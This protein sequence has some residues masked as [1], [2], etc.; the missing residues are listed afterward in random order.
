MVGAISVFLPIPRSLGQGAAYGCTNRFAARGRRVNLVPGTV[1]GAF[2]A[3]CSLRAHSPSGRLDVSP[4]QPPHLSTCPIGQCPPDPAESHGTVY[5][6]LALP[7]Q[8]PQESGQET[9]T[10][11]RQCV[12]LSSPLRP[13]PPL[14]PAKAPTSSAA[15]WVPASRVARPWRPAATW[16][17]PLRLAASPVWSATTSRRSSAAD[18]TAGP[19]AGTEGAPSL[20]A[21][22]PI[23]MQRRP[24][25]RLRAAFVV[26]QQRPKARK[27][28]GLTCSTRS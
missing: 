9:D 16:R 14:L 28:K 15:R 27:T 1:W 18:L 6:A 12:P 4:N 2:S 25:H 11:S 21:S 5:N 26:A 22:R 3:P 7:W 8:M 23:S 10:E 20:T 17:A 24:K 19:R 13:A